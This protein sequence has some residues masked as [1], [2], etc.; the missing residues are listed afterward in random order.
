MNYTRSMPEYVCSRYIHFHSFSIYSI[1]NYIWLQAC[2]NYSTVPI[3]QP[4]FIR[5][6]VLSDVPFRHKS[7]W[8]TEFYPDRSCL[9][10]TTKPGDCYRR[11]AVQVLVWLCWNERM[12]PQKELF[13]T[14]F[15][16]IN[17]LICIML[18]AVCYKIFYLTPFSVS[19]V[20]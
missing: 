6:S 20:I 8:G 16:K 1:T 2:Y 17:S 11:S 3:I 18:N 15:L 7:Q 5:H 19:F 9:R 14:N 4:S 10:W 13:I 12:E